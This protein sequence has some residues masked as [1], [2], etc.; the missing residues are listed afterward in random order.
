MSS[1]ITFQDDSKSSVVRKAMHWMDEKDKALKE[2]GS[3]IYRQHPSIGTPRWCGYTN[4][5]KEIWEL[6]ITLLK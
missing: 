1:T 5:H 2:R 4:E 6:T 3:S